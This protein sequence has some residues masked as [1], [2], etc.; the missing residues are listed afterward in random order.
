MTAL[1]TDLVEIFRLIAQ[2]TVGN[3]PGRI[4]P[5]ARTRRTKSYPWLK[6]PRAEARRQVRTYDHL[7]CA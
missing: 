4:E 6:L 3:R 5:R 7:L 1:Q 2:L